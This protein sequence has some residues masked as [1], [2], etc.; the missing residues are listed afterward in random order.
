MMANKGEDPVNLMHQF[1]NRIQVQPDVELGQEDI[2]GLRIL[3]KGLGID[4]LQSEPSEPSPRNAKS[5]YEAISSNKHLDSEQLR[6]FKAQFQSHQ[7]L[8]EKVIC[9]DVD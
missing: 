2:N 7:S 4:N 3:F 9:Q 8:Y 6:K 5:V 1:L